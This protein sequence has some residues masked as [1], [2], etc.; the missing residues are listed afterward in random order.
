MMIVL[1]DLPEDEIE[2]DNVLQ[3]T[4]ASALEASCDIL[5]RGFQ[6]GIGE[7]LTLRNWF[8]TNPWAR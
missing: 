8:A 2:E 5:F 7:C 4:V 1:A 6:T 3:S